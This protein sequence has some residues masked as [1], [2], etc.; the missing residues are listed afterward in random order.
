MLPAV[1][2]VGLREGDVNG[3]RILLD[4][5]SD[6]PGLGFDRFAQAFSQI[7]QESD[8][9]F[10][11]GIFGEWGSGKTTL[12]RAIE[13]EL[14]KDDTVVLVWFNAWRYEKEEHLIVPLLDTLREALVDWAGRSKASPSAK[15]RAI[16]AAATVGKAAR[17]ILAGLT[18]K[19][20]MPGGGPEVA[21]EA[22]KVLADWR[23]SDSAA[24]RRSSEEPQSFY[25]ASF[26]ALQ[27]ALAQFVE[28]RA[29]RIVVFVDDL[30][31]CLPLKAL[32]I[33]ESMKLFFDLE[34][35]I[36]VVG[37][38]RR[39]VERSIKAKFQVE[40]LLQDEEADAG[41]EGPE[42]LKKIF[43]V[44]FTLP[45]VSHA[46]LDEFLE[47]IYGA[48]LSPEQRDDLQSRVRPH[49]DSIITE[50]GVNPREIK[51]YINAYT[52]QMRTRPEL[53]PDTVLG[54]QTIAFQPDW[55]EAYDVLLAEREVFTSIV[56]RRLEGDR[57][58]VEN[59]WPDLKSIPESFYGYLSSPAGDSLLHAP[60]LDPYIH[61][62]EA[63]RSTQ[64][65][66]AD[67]YGL[68][69]AQRGLLRRFDDSADP[70]GRVGMVERFNQ[71][72]HGLRSALTRISTAP[73]GMLVLREVEE[74][75][76]RPELE[77]S[78]KASS[79]DDPILRAWREAA[80]ALL[81]R[82]QAYLREARRLSGVGP[83]R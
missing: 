55:E 35:F 7:I 74:F 28:G 46:Q 22:S 63:T 1:H 23:T 12:M 39:V 15:E 57:H 2:H 11:I 10:A 54:L 70:S 60:S 40:R 37:L 72:L 29:R 81:D 42:Y 33:L 62:I 8:P 50:S 59:L 5:P 25:H 67:L 68:L 36:F 66:L 61:S 30:D 24:D 69:G 78:S 43:Q 47:S 13:A 80:G 79:I 52:V 9:R 26:K 27:G 49:L 34:G 58:A 73:Q 44:P 48:D 21:L 82:V 17:A 71:E 45:P 75:S 19:A 65:G 51:R 18:L 76:K 77:L 38:D 14:S 53:D 83:S 32:E 4:S 31:R 64:S 6:R 56:R 41:I 20:R 3:Y 16:K